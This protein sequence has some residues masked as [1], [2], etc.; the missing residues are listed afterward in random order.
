MP[1]SLYMIEEIEELRKLDMYNQYHFM[2]QQKAHIVQIHVEFTFATVPNMTDK[3][4]YSIWHLKSLNLDHMYI[5][6]VNCDFNCDFN[7]L[8]P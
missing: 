5:I 6:Y 7:N 3:S 8:Y 4:V 2:Y 1:C